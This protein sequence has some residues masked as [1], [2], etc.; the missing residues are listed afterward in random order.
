MKRTF[1]FNYF[2]LS[3]SFIIKSQFIILLIFFIEHITLLLENVKSLVIGM[4]IL[5]KNSNNITTLK[6]Y[7]DTY[8]LNHLS[9]LYEFRYLISSD[10][11][12]YPPTLYILIIILLFVNYIL[13]FCKIMHSNRIIVSI[14]VNLY[15]LCFFA[16][17]L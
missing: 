2:E 5:I 16:Y 10:Y 12:L 1:H 3:F 13:L 9:L 11:N 15:N 4:N 6:E 7:N 17:L 8:F 14:I